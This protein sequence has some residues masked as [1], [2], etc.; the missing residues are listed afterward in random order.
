[1]DVSSEEW[2]DSFNLN[3]VSTIRLCKAFAPG[4]VERR[5]GRIVNISSLAA[6]NSGGY[7]HDYGSA[8]A[9][10]DHITVNLSKTL[11]PNGVTVNAVVPGTIM[12]PAVERWLDILRKQNNW[13][14]D[15]ARMSGSTR[16]SSSSSRSRGSPP[17]GNRAAVVFLCSQRPS[18]SP[19][20]RSES[21]VGRPRRAER[22]TDIATQASHRR[23]GPVRARARRMAGLLAAAVRRRARRLGDLDPHLFDGLLL[24]A[25]AGR[26]PLD[27]GGGLDRHH[28]R[29]R[30]RR[31]AQSLVGTLIDRVG[32]RRVGLFGIAFICT[33][34]ALPAPPP[35]RRPTGSGC[36]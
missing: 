9:A 36:G 14:D 35:A 28:R 29:H 5:W 8:K 32:P 24:P 4:M 31:G 10:I 20:P 23:P 13:P 33:A 21:M 16:A 17:G 34:M 12:T 25:A 27:P 30:H 22:V 15:L 7:L 11:A 18:T 26:V 19:A 1:M 2:L 3:V 6:Q